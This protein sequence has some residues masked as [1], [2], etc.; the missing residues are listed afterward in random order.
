[1]K[2]PHERPALQC[3]FEQPQVQPDGV[4]HR[5]D[6]RPRRRRL[7]RN[8]GRRRAPLHVRPGAD[9][10]DV[11]ERRLA[12]IRR[13][14]G[15]VPPGPHGIGDARG[16]RRDRSRGAPGSCMAAPFERRSGSRRTSETRSR[17]W[18]RLRR[19]TTRRGSKRCGRPRRASP[20]SRTSHRSTPP[21]H[22]T[23]PP[24]AYTLS[25]PGGVGRGTGGSGGSGSTA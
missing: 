21:F 14:R 11:A 25:G 20:A 5:R 6:S 1:M 3:R 8:E 16:P 12:R 23:L 4:R 15:G 9:A 2:A 7:G 17:T 13:R 10:G 24:R 18:W 22:A 19:C